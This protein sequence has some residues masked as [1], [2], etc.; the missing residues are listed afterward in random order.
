VI[1]RPAETPT[2][3][4][5]QALNLSA[6]RDQ[7][8]S[9]IVLH[10][11]YA[12]PRYICPLRQ[13]SISYVL[14]ILSLISPTNLSTLAGWELHRLEE[15]YVRRSNRNTFTSGAIYVDG[16]YVNPAAGPATATATPNGTGSSKLSKLSVTS[17][18][19]ADV[20]G[21]RRSRGWGYKGPVA[22]VGNWVQ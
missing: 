21:K 15:R 11:K 7:A 2:Q 13:T 8:S 17:L 14:T 4:L 9:A 1:A 3:A 12:F 5:S 20:A 22:S 19:S 16:E 18:K 10:R 6:P